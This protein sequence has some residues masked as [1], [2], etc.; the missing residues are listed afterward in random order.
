[1]LDEPRKRTDKKA[2]IL[3]ELHKIRYARFRLEF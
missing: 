3:D 1:M 2:D